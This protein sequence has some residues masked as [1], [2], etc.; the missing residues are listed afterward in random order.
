MFP[1]SHEK[2]LQIVLCTK[3]FETSID[4]QRPNAQRSR[5]FPPGLIKTSVEITW[6][7][8]EALLFVVKRKKGTWKQNLPCAAGWGLPVWSSRSAE[9]GTSD[10]VENKE[11]GPATDTEY[12]P[13]VKFCPN[14]DIPRI[15]NFSGITLW[16]KRSCMKITAWF[17]FFRNSKQISS[18]FSKIQQKLKSDYGKNCDFFPK[19]Q[20]FRN[21]LQKQ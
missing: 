10:W 20:K 3:V 18:N 12:Q 15:S 19:K 8:Q 7:H 16:R 5:F 6:K 4:L 11:S 21:V 1:Q 13:D 14:I 17:D 9:L 2:I